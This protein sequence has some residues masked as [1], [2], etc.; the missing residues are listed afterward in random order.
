M[1]IQFEEEFLSFEKI[2]KNPFV[3]WGVEKWKERNDCFVEIYVRG[4]AIAR[5][6]CLL[7]GEVKLRFDPKPEPISRVK[8]DIEQ[9][10]N[11]IP[12]LEEFQQFS[13]PAEIIDNQTNL[14][15]HFVCSKATL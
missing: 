7:R 4:E 9:W 15:E 1:V 12:S 2:R 6:F 10:P 8:L 11:I 14:S 13:K 5:D 3:Y